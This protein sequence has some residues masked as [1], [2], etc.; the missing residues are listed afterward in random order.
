MKH[1]FRSIA[2]CAL[3]LPVVAACATKGFV[4]ERLAA[5]RTSIDSAAAAEQQARMSGD[6]ALRTD[7]TGTTR[8]VAQLSQD[9]AQMKTQMAQLRQDLTAMKNDYDMRISA[10]ED[11]LHFVMPVTFG[12][13]KTSPADSATPALDR[14]ASV[15]KKYYPTSL[16]TVEGF[17]DPAGSASYNLKLS[18]KRADAVASYL[19]EQGVPSENIRTVGYGET[20]LVVPGAFKNRP[21]ADQNRR[22][23]FV[24]ETSNAAE[25]ITA[26]ESGSGS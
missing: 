2:V 10:M 19:T 24:I 18:K 12:F 7:L 16:I 8:D 23:T 25:V 4:R 5:E 13:D 17:A 15:A 6:A 1:T 26:L 11:G 20:R 3:V 22:V 14:F 9:V 21:G